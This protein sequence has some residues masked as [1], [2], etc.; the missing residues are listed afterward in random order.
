LDRALKRPWYT[1]VVA[2]LIFGGA[3]ALIPVIGFSLF[4]ASEKPQFLIRITAPLQANIY[5]TDSITRQIERELDSLPEV[6]YFAANVGKGNPR[7]YYNVE[8]AN[9]RADFAEIF[10]QLQPETSARDKEAL[11]ER[12]RQRWTPYLGAKVEVKNFE[13][14]VPVIS[15]VEV[16][17]FGDN[18]DTLKQLASRVET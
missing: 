9:E 3:L 15:P 13:Q 18:L 1:V 7:I 12:L 4:P 17:L 16:R 5:T 8:Q 2:I 10:V 14:G 11:I 6:Q